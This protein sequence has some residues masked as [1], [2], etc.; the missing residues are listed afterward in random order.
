MAKNKLKKFEQ[1]KSYEHVKQPT[2]QELKE[3]YYLKGRWKQDFFNNQCPIILELGC[4]KGEYSYALAQKHSDKNFIGVDIKGAR[5]WKGATDSKN[6]NVKNIGFLRIRIEWIESCFDKNEI[7]EIWITFPDPQIKKRRATKR[8]THPN[9]LK[10]YS[11][12]LKTNG[13]I[14]LKTDS[15][16]LHN[17][18]L[19]NILNS[20]HFLHEHSNDIY[21]NGNT[22]EN[23]DI[24]THYEKLHLD[25]GLPI[26][27]I[28][29]SLK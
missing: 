17:F 3:G 26:T 2:L 15:Q 27:Y 24:K 10:R 8:L 28:K 16:F 18:T 14:H 1:L 25:K 7:D 13:F 20:G 6:Q 9:F 19:E 21:V 29:F 4:G 22:F 12:I 5:I 23:M 11:R